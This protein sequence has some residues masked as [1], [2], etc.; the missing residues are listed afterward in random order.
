LRYY[1]TLVVLKSEKKCSCRERIQMP[2]MMPENKVIP[3]QGSV[4]LGRLHETIERTQN[5]YKLGEYP[6]E[7]YSV[8]I[9]G[10][11]P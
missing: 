5:H 7:S 10:N 3:L 9:I 2:E 11:Q 4:S 6:E 8:V 1:L